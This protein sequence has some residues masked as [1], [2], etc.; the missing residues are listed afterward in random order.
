MLQKQTPLQPKE[1][2]LL[3]VS[4]H[5]VNFNLTCPIEYKINNAKSTQQ[6]IAIWSGV[7]WIM[8]NHMHKRLHLCL[9]L[10]RVLGRRTGYSN[11]VA[12]WLQ[13]TAAASLTVYQ[14]GRI[15]SCLSCL[16][17]FIV[18]RNRRWDREE[19]EE[20]EKEDHGLARDVLSFFLKKAVKTS[21]N[22]VIPA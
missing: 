22:S 5:T 8:T 19:E 7:M 20:E 11:T 18:G 13:I 16:P 4:L 10:I 1:G 6:E 3:D 9:H 21:I 15:H 14:R 12:L 2:I 17:W